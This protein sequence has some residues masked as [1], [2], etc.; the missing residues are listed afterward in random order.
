MIAK[1]NTGIKLLVTA[2]GIGSWPA[3]KII[4]SLIFI[5]VVY[6]AR[7]IGIGWISTTV[8]TLLGILLMIIFAYTQ[9]EERQSITLSRMMGLAGALYSVPFTL[10]KVS[11]IFFIFTFLSILFGTVLYPLLFNKKEDPAYDAESLIPL[12]I[13]DTIAAVITLAMYYAVTFF[14]NI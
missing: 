2:G 8:L 12:I 4:A 14:L 9:P 11:F 10:K 1:I 3:G 13:C 7:I 5:P 6:L